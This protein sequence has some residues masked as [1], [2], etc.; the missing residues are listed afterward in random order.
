MQSLLG[1][2]RGGEIRDQPVSFRR[3]RAG[4]GWAGGPLGL[5]CVLQE[6]RR[7]VADTLARSCKGLQ[8]P[9]PAAS[10]GAWAVEPASEQPASCVRALGVPTSRA[11]PLSLPVSQQQWAGAGAG[12]QQ[13][14]AGAGC[15]SLR[16]SVTPALLVLCSVLTGV[17]EQGTGAPAPL[18]GVL[19]LALRSWVPRSSPH[20]GPLCLPGSGDCWG[21]FHLNSR[22][23]KERVSVCWSLPRT[24]RTARAGLC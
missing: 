9:G 16:P 13:Q 15:R 1:W 6:G 19:P 2:H 12:S 24:A 14:R 18:D 20:P 10:R 4:S 22:I 3:E 17:S 11:W 23:N 8:A 21:P 5:Q 7:A